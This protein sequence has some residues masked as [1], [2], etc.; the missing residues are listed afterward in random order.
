MNIVL[1]EE[2]F[3]NEWKKVRM[4]KQILSEDEERKYRPALYFR[5]IPGSTN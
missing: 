2:V 5:K 4:E 3:P 1:K